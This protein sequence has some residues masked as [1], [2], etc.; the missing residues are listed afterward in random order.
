LG[1][2]FIFYN[3]L[4]TNEY[5]NKISEILEITQ[6]HKQLND[7][8]KNYY[9]ESTN[10][11]EMCWGCIIFLLFGAKRYGDWIQAEISKK[12]YFMLQ[13]TDLFCQLYSYIIGA[14]TIIPNQYNQNIAYNYIPDDDIVETDTNTYIKKISKNILDKI[15]DNTT[16]NVVN[17]S[18]IL[19]NNLVNTK[20]DDK[21]LYEGLETIETG[22]VSR[23]YF[24][25]YLKYKIKYNEL[26]KN[27][28]N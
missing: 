1:I 25:K 14:P 21:I 19:D 2:E 28:A 15:S 17:I 12:Y 16:N 13:T 11:L 20:P 4:V 6:L 5:Y 10:S 3:E 27:I 7:I 8:Y 24:N 23:F 18:K 22:N 26:K 9:V